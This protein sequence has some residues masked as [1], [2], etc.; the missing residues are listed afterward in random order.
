MARQPK[1]GLD[2]FPLDVHTDDKIELLEAEHGLTGFAIYVKLLQKIYSEGYFYKIGEDELLLTARRLNVDINPL[3]DV[4]NSCIKR[5][6]FNNVVYEKYNVLT[7]RGIQKRYFEATVRR[8]EITLISEYWLDVEYDSKITTFINVD[9]NPLNVDISTQSKVKKSKEEKSKEKKDDLFLIFKEAHHEYSTGKK[10]GAV[11]E[12]EWLKK[13]H[14]DWEEIIPI[15]KDCVIAYKKHL[16]K[17]KASSGFAPEKH[18]QGWIT[19]RR[20]ETYTTDNM[21]PKKMKILKTHEG[22]TIEV[23]V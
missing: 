8:K 10:R 3:N 13:Q 20:W 9:I 1:Q 19:D 7:S 4:I 12:Y 23:E 6:L 16:A 5:N 18:M 2:Y 21:E 22:E 11:T 14:K 15:L 17:E